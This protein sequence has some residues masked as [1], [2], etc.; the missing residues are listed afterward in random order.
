M[1]PADFA[2][3]PPGPRESALVLGA[4]LG[5]ILVQAA[6]RTWQTTLAGPCLWAI[7]VTVFLTVLVDHQF[8]ADSHGSALVRFAL[9][10][11]TFC[12]L[13]AVLGAKRPQHRGWQWVVASLWLVLVWPAG[14]A[15]LAGVGLELFI[16]WKLFLLGLIALGVVNYLPTRHWL[17][18]LLVAAGQLALLWEFL[19]SANPAKQVGDFPSPWVASSPPP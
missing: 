5:V 17:A 10:A 4:L 3:I 16:A 12:P 6:R 9:A 18:A 2:T 8:D 7:S 19:G 15:A 13:M 14:Q 1:S 11:A